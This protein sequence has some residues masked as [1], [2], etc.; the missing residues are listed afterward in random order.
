M[1]LIAH[2]Y[3]LR[4][5]LTNK[6]L[7]RQVMEIWQLPSTKVFCRLWHAIWKVQGHSGSPQSCAVHNSELLNI[8]LIFFPLFRLEVLICV[9]QDPGPEGTSPYITSCLWGRIRCFH[10]FGV[11]AAFLHYLSISNDRFPL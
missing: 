10:V 11:S 2:A 6:S 9:S 5:S 8:N 1:K 3:F 7:F 4:F